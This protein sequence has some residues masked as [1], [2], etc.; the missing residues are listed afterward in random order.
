MANTLKF[1]TSSKGS[2]DPDSVT[3]LR[4]GDRIVFFDDVYKFHRDGFTLYNPNGDDKAL[5]LSNGILGFLSRLGIKTY[6]ESNSGYLGS[7][8]LRR[9]VITG[10]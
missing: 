8:K 6:P 1:Y 4:V 9:F 2:A 10:L 7:D 3:E 5:D